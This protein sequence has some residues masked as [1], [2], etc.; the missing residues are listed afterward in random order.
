VEIVAVPE[1][2][3]GEVDTPALKAMLRRR[4]RGREASGT[5]KKRRV[6]NISHLAPFILGEIH[7]VV[8]DLLDALEGETEVEDADEEELL[9]GF[10]EVVSGHL[11][12]SPLRVHVHGESGQRSLGGDGLQTRLRIAG[13]DDESADHTYRLVIE[14]EEHPL[15]SSHLADGPRC[16]DFPGDL[17]Y[18][19]G[20]GKFFGSHR[21]RVARQ[22]RFGTHASMSLRPGGRQP[23]PC[24]LGLKLIH[25]CSC[26]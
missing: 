24:A 19:F 11:T 5:K 17:T 18:L 23:A 13:Q 20:I 12:H 16:G 22:D 4:A 8:A 26:F 21:L 9:G 2:V 25:L 3:A 15:H 14:V 10:E 6:A 1:P 7:H